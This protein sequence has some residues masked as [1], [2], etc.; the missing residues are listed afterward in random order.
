ME[1]LWHLLILGLACHF[2]SCSG[3][4]GAKII[5]TPQQCRRARF[6]PGHN[7]AGEGFDIVKMQQKNAYVINMQIW[8]RPNGTCTLIRNSYLGGILQKLPLAAVNWRALSKCKMSVSSK[9]YESSESLVN[10]STSS[11]SN[12]WKIGLSFPVKPGVSVGVAFGGTHSRE[13][14]YAMRKSRKD[15]YSFTSHEVH[16]SFYRY[17]VAASV[18]LHREFRVST[19]KLPKYYNYRTKAAYQDLIDT[20]GTHY[21]R[22]VE[23]GGKMKSVTAIRTC[24]ATM[25][26][27]TDTAVKDCLDVEASAT[28]G[29]SA[30]LRAEYHRC[31]A[32]KR[33]LGTS[34][35]FSSM[36]RERQNQ[37]VGGK[38]N[39]PDLLFSGG[40]NRYAYHEWLKSLKTIP[41]V[42]SYSLRPLHWLIRH[43]NPVRAGLKKAIEEYIGKNALVQRCS[44]S[45]R[46]GRRTSARD[47]CACVCYSNANIRSN[48]C[49]AGVGLATLTVYGLKG[50]KLYGDRFTQ[51]DG[52]VRVSYGSQIKRTEVINNNDNPNWPETFY[53]GPVKLTMGTRIYFEVYDADSR[54]NSDLLGTCSFRP[55]RGTVSDTCMFKYGTF[56]FSYRVTCAPSLGGQYCQHYIPSPMSASLAKKFHSR[57]GF[58]AGERWKELLDRNRS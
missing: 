41:S 21:I 8:K 33:K 37:M 51:T 4:L 56:F 50:R 55:R 15:K 46:I 38:I 53:F 32:L 13:A 52:S 29:Y 26:G 27:L 28:F 35:S 23:L 47:S 3:I 5:G 7:L 9:I 17:R 24:K 40:S 31:Q 19:M 16:C 49:P 42:V 43:N 39:R 45:C 1:G 22:K 25:S 20:Y 34:S 18:P 57:N 36:F 14:S 10:D 30:S 2:L 54:W 6:V 48:C 58:L 12:N 44:G 11:V